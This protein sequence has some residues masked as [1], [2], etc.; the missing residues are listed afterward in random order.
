MN[1][2]ASFEETVQVAEDSWRPMLRTLVI[3]E[4]TT[5]QEIRSWSRQT[6]RETL[7]EDFKMPNIIISE[8]V[9]I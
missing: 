2:V 6:L 8:S 7:R 3:T 5:I 9:S 1:Y 4:T